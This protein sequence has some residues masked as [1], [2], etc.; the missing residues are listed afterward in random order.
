M[1]EEKQAETTAEDNPLGDGG[2]KA[3]QAEREARK[4][5]EKALAE[6]KETWEAEKAELAGKLSR[7][8]QAKQAA[9]LSVLRTSVL[10]SKKVPERLAGYV[11]GGTKEELEASADKVLADFA[12]PSPDTS[13]ENEK[14]SSFGLRPDMTQGEANNVPLNG[15]A[16]TEALMQIYKN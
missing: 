3:L 12:P 1:S 15:S 7:E 5:A 9:E 11:T 16:L 10:A 8:T 2:I 14:T 13:S 6:H 4:A